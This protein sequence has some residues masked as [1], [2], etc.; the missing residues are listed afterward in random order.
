MK[1]VEVKKEVLVPVVIIVIILL[2]AIV[3]F[4]AGPSTNAGKGQQLSQG[5]VCGDNVCN[6]NET[7][8]SCPADCTLTD[9]PM[10]QTEGGQG[11]APAM[12]F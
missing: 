11:T 8:D 6:S 10:P 7:K 4:V 12:P 1:M 5:A 9:I 2:A 3:L